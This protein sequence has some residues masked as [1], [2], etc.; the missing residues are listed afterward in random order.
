[1]ELLRTISSWINTPLFHI[2][3]TAITANHVLVFLLTIVLA[4][5]AGKIVRRITA[6]AVATRHADDRGGLAYAT[7]R[8]AQYLTVIV[9]LLVGLENI[10]ISI[11][12]LA[13]FGAVI[14]V[15]LGFGM[16]A[17]VN[18]VVSGLVLLIERP[19]AKG[20]FIRVD[21]VEGRVQGIAMRATTLVTRDGVTVV[22]PNSKLIAGL[23]SDYAAAS[24]SYRLH[25][26]VGVAYD[27]DPEKVKQT[28]VAVAAA[29]D[30]VCA[31]PAPE[32]LFT[33]FADSALSFEL[34]AWIKAPEFA[35]SIASGLR[36][37]IVRAFRE[38]DIVI[39]FPQRELRLTAPPGYPLPTPSARAN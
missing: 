9:V 35:P 3:R 13:A 25:V 7:A 37:A 19:I 12:A 14:S 17:Y 6:R 11:T 23:V 31:E 38:H 5:V 22:V 26:K 20:E 36:F 21:E 4:Y 18:N 39:P 32:V 16:Q 33:D 29:C 34:C 8:I 10:G 2:G 1:M 24:R 28:L 15:G 30:D 27:S